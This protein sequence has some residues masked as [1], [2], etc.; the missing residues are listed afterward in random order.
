MSRSFALVALLASFAA[1]A[2]AQS[3][4]L[5]KAPPAHN[6]VAVISFDAAVFSTNEFRRDYADLQKMY[7]PRRAQIQSL[8]NEIKSLQTQLQAQ[9]VKLSDLERTNRTLAI[10]RKQIQLRRLVQDSQNDF[11]QEVQQHYSDVAAKLNTVVAAYAKEHGYTLVF[12]I[13]RQT[14]NRPVLWA[15]PSADIT[16]PVIDVYNAK[17]GIPAPPPQSASSPAAPAPRPHTSH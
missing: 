14:Q 1:I 3:R 13:L 5:A 7:A 10:E 8:T 12:G 2:S 15:N 11:E 4:P 17:S 9:G 6:R 16:R